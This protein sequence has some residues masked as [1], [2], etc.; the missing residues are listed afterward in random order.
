MEL[1]YFNKQVRHNQPPD[2]ARPDGF[3]YNQNKVTIDG[4]GRTQQLITLSYS[5]GLEP[6]GWYRAG[7]ELWR[8]R[9]L[10]GFHGP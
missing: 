2:G 8:K 3:Y 5:E 1:R 9:E 6:V 7:I 4:A 10:R